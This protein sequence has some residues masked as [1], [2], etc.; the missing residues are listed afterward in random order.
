MQHPRD[1]PATNPARRPARARKLPRRPFPA[2]FHRAARP[3]GRWPISVVIPRFL[4]SVLCLCRGCVMGVVN[5]PGLGS[6]AGVGAP[7][8]IPVKLSTHSGHKP[9]TKTCISAKLPPAPSPTPLPCRLSPSR[10]PTNASRESKALLAPGRRRP[11]P[12]EPSA[13]GT[14]VRT[15]LSRSPRT[16]RAPCGPSAASGLPMIRDA[17]SEVSTTQLAGPSSLHV[18]GPEL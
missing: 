10:P 9:A 7:C 12:T 17:V 4:S 16:G 1:T 8:T 14:R 18:P 15:A 6:G 13:P 5:T 11:P 3:G 2:A